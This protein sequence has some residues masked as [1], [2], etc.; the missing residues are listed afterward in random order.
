MKKNILFGFAACGAMLLSANV[1]TAQEA[2]AVEEVTITETEA[3]EC[4]DHFYSE[5]G[6]NWFLQIGAGMELPMTDRIAED[7]KSV[8]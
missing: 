5:R 4:G 6:A 3:V 7:R 8:V 1:A 2:V